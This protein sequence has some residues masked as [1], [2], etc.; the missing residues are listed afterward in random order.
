MCT[1]EQL[2]HAGL[3]KLTTFSKLS[4]TATA[5]LLLIATNSLALKT[6]FSGVSCKN[7]YQIGISNNNKMAIMDADGNSLYRWTHGTNQ[8][9]WSER[10]QT[11]R[12]S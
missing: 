7:E 12:W 5:D 4:V 6:I 2:K 8:W 1:Q 3:Q 9:A 11:L 10:W